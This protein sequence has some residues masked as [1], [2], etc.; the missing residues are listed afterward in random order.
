M[1]QVYIN[2][3]KRLHPTVKLSEGE[4]QKIINEEKKAYDATRKAK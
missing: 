2:D 4:K 1:I 3:V